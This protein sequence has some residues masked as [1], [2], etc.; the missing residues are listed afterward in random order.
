MS[1]AEVLRHQVLHPLGLTLREVWLGRDEAV[2]LCAGAGSQATI[3]YRVW[4]N[5]WLLGHQTPGC[6][7]VQGLLP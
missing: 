3:G 2:L 4:F 6:L 5:H 7:W 1:T